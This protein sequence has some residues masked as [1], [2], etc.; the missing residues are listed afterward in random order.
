LRTSRFGQQRLAVLLLGAG[1]W[2]DLPTTEAGEDVTDPSGKPFASTADTTDQRATLEELADGVFAYTAQGDPNVG[3]IVGP[4]AALVVD[5]RATP[6]HAQEWI[7]VIRAE[8]TDKP[9]RWI[10]LTHYHAVRT[11]GASAYDAEVI[12]AHEQTRAWIHERG[13]QDFES[14]A[15]R[16]PR[17]FRDIDS[18]PGLTYPDVTF[19]D[20]LTLVLGGREVRLAYYGRGHTEGDIGIWLPAERVLFAGDLMEAR[21]APYCGDAF[22]RDWMTTTLDRVAA[23]RPRAVVPGRGRAVLGDEVAAAITET[24]GYLRTLH[25]AVREVV[26]R[27]GDLKEAFDAAYAALKLRFGDWWIFEHVIPFNVSRMYDE[28]VGA[29]PRI[30]TATRDQEIWQQLQS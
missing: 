8:I 28:L 3:C 19:T 14:E 1:V 4:D 22:V 13:E 25:D 15:R 29:R 5:A 21:A 20:E 7:D 26:L 18:I 2:S 11:L 16:F 27:E 12:I 30:W 24:R 6:T 9:I 17:L 10:V 23:L